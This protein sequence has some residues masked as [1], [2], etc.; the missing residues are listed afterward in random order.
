M[1][2]ESEWSSPLKSVNSANLDSLWYCA[3][4][5]DWLQPQIS[6]EISTWT[7]LNEISPA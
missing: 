3:L 6:Q 1:L 2:R 7:W 4:V 5:N